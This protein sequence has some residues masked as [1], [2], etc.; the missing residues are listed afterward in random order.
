M[1]S[2][3]EEVEVEVEVGRPTTLRGASP[4]EKAEEKLEMQ[5]LQSKYRLRNTRFL[6]VG[7]LRLLIL[8]TK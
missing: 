5:F 2:L 6:R 4:K 8:S 3:E 7:R 1:F